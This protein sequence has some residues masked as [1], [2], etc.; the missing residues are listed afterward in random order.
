MIGPVASQAATSS[1]WFE[2]KLT[3]DGLMTLI[4]GVIAPFYHW[5]EANAEAE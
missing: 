5:I 2:A 3:L 4:G 1:S